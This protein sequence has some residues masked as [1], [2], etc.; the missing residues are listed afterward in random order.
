MNNEELI[1]ALRCCG[2]MIIDCKK[3]CPYYGKENCSA[4]K[5]AAAA[6]E[7]EAAEK[8]IAELES[9]M[10]KEGE[11][12]EVHDWLHIPQEERGT[13]RCSACGQVMKYPWNYCPNCGSVMKGGCK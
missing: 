7:L 3:Q 5:D 4:R 6:Y 9:Q 8:R 11:W 13:Y 2:S 12:I 1:K 10:P